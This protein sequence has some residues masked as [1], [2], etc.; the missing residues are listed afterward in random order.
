[1]AAAQQALGEGLWEDRVLVKAGLPVRYT[2]GIPQSGGR[3]Q[4][5]PSSS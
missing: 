5:R 3:G 4:A 2:E 1:M